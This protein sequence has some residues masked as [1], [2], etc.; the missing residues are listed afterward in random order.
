[1]MGTRFIGRVEVVA[2]SAVDREI[3]QLSPALAGSELRAAG[4]RL[5]VAQAV[6]AAAARLRL[7]NCLT[8]RWS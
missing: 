6:E 1:M 2:E 5:V 8:H 3:D 7:L 4:Y